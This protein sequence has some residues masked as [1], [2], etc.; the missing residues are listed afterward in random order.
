[1]V[2]W[3]S[4]ASNGRSREVLARLSSFY[5]DTRGWRALH[6]RGKLPGSTQGVPEEGALVKRRSSGKKVPHDPIREPNPNSKTLTLTLTINP[7]P[8]LSP[9]SNTTMTLIRV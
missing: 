7:N 4:T 6:P 2:Q 3:E 8:K 1:M 9:Y 5:Q